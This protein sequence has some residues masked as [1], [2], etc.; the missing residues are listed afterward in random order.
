M[1]RY[2]AG[3]LGET[4]LL[5][6][7]MSFVIYILLGLM[8]GDPIDLMVSGNPNMTSADAE[9]LRR[10][11]G[12]DQ[13]LLDRYGNWLWQALQGDFGY[14]RTHGKPVLEILWDRLS[15]TLLLMGLSFSLAL[16]LAL[17]IG[18]VAAMKPHSSID[19][20]V[21]L[22]CFVGISIP[23]F[24]LALLL[25]IVFA[26][27]LG[28]LP[29]GGMGPIEGD[30]GFWQK[31]SY[32]VLP[33][34]TLTMA[35]VGDYTRFVRASM[36]E[37]MR[38]DYVRT[39]RAKGASRRRIVWGHALRNALIPVVT[40]VALQFGS[41]FSGALITETMF[42]YLGMGKTIYDAIMANDYNLALIGLMFATLLV[43]ISNLVADMLYALLDP[44]ISY[45]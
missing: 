2:F 45:R 29:A 23:H 34:A 41:L 14:S 37:T 8:P 32:L 5:L 21:N 1:I 3:R 19:H 13:P 30:A 24:W 11:Y 28:W 9:R 4:L 16:L 22:F 35:S 31:A 33:V 36:M 12:L 42:S 17:P 25:I 43:M 18:V 20:G 38:Q 39:A 40:V 6:L 44:R 7:V 26:V 15:N 27:F 10:I